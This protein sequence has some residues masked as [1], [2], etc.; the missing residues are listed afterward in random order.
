[1]ASYNLKIFRPDPEW[2]IEGKYINTTH[3]N[4]HSNPKYP[5]EG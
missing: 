1:M 4:G 3:L 5:G 2:A